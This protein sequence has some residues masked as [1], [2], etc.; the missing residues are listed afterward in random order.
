[1]GKYIVFLVLILCLSVSCSKKDELSFYDIVVTDDQGNILFSNSD[2]QWNPSPMPTEGNG[3]YIDQL[4]FYIDSIYNGDSNLSLNFN[5]QLPDTIQI[6]AF[7]NPVSNLD[8]LKIKLRCSKGICLYSF[9][10]EGLVGRFPG[11]GSGIGEFY[12]NNI[13]ECKKEFNFQISGQINFPTDD[14]R[15][16]FVIITED[17]CVY[18]AFGNIMVI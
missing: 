7:P 12:Q 16:S 1:M 10:Y 2:A 9:G 15:I 3:P 8:D 13:S 17:G 11:G 4:N 14:L 5:C 18:E 6:I